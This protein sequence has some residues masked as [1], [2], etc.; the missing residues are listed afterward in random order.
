MWSDQ[1]LPDQLRLRPSRAVVSSGPS[2]PCATR[3]P[4]RRW[5]S[6]SG[7]ACRPCAQPRPRRSARRPPPT[8][9]RARGGCTGG[10]RLPDSAPD[11]KGLGLGQGRYGGWSAF[12]GGFGELHRA[13]GTARRA[14]QQ[15]GTLGGGNHF[16]E[17]TVD[18]DEQVW[19]MLH[20]GSRNI[21]KE[22]AE[23][24]INDAKGLDHNVDLPDRD[25]AVFLAGTPQMD[26]YLRDLYWAQGYAA[27]NR[28]VMMA[29]F[30]GSSPRHSA[31]G[32]EVE[33]GEQIS[34]HHNY[35]ARGD[36]RT[37]RADRHPQGRDPRRPRGVRAHPGLDG[38]RS[39]MV[40]GLG[41]PAS[42]WSASHGAGRKMSR[43]GKADLHRRGPRRPDRRRGVSQGRRRRRRDPRRLQGPRVPSS[44]PRASRTA[45]RGRRA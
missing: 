45:R 28:A 20:S 36:L 11:I 4:L 14:T 38:H 39:Y 8:A 21:G 24:H 40:K 33:Y 23:R 12:W 5:G 6:T 43:E 42:Y 37:A 10:V 29:L 32:L 41:N 15:M 18:D 7:A 44:N 25:L 19:L 31:R 3:S 27:R 34:A 9:P 26:E 22:I 1:R 30:S 16:L 35:V 17:L 13:C 2:S